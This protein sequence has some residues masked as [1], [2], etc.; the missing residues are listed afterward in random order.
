MLEFIN[1]FSDNKEI[2]IKIF[3]KE[4]EPKH[5]PPYA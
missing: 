5:K 1:F 3:E 4:D 2:L